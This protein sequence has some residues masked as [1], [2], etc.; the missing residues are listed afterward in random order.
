MIPRTL[1]RLYIYLLLLAFIWLAPAYTYK[2]HNSEAELKDVLTELGD[3]MSSDHLHILR[4]RGI[5]EQ[6]GGLHVINYT[7]PCN[8][9]TAENQYQT[10]DLTDA[11][12][13]QV[14]VYMSFIDLLAVCYS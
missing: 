11:S 10:I 9:T 3:L 12:G 7:F 5:V 13:G 4:K 1:Q 6:Y 8:Q 2:L 14:K